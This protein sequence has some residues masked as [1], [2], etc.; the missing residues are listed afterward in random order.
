MSDQVNT[1]DLFSCWKL[2]H[3][4]L[5]CLLLWLELTVLLDASWQTLDD[6]LVENQTLAKQ[7]KKTNGPSASYLSSYQ[8]QTL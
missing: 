7:N 2:S 4:W 1:S 3:E 6:L 5:V 8:G